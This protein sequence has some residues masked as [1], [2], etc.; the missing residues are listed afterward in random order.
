MLCVYPQYVRKVFH[1]CS[2]YILHCSCFKITKP[3]FAC[4]M[5]APS[6]QKWLT[7][8]LICAA[9]ICSNTAASTSSIEDPLLLPDGYAR[10]ESVMDE[11]R[12][13][14]EVRIIRRHAESF[15]SGSGF[16]DSLTPEVPPE[17]ERSPGPPGPLT[18]QM[19][20]QLLDCWWGAF[21]PQLAL[22]AP[23]G[24]QSCSILLTVAGPTTA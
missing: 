12:D 11:I 2:V 20:Q 14:E 18:P 6:P 9:S 4:E 17:D 8:A 22:P 10:L 15:G 1:A 23:E 13:G 7:L 21:K 16:N 5:T 24:G 19:L 3:T